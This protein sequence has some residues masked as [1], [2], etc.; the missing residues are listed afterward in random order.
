MARSSERQAALEVVGAY[1]QEQLSMLLGRAAEAVDRFRSGEVDAFETDAVLFQYGR[2]AKEL[3]KFCNLGDVFSTA[4][5]IADGPV[6]D[7]WARG[8]FRNR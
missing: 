3:W 1:H 2:A 6:M 8:A 5:V 4:A 7:W